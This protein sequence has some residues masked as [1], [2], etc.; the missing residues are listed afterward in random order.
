M[1]DRFELLIGNKISDIKCKNILV[2]G[3]GGVGSY[4]VESLVR[5]GIE[6]ITLID[7]DIIDVTNLN[8]QLM[9]DTTNIGKYKTDVL[10]S[11]IKLIN[12]NIKVITKTIFLN[13]DN[14]SIVTKD[15]DYVVDACDTVK[16]KISLI[17]TC[18]N[19]GIKLISV[20]GT[21]NKMDPS[22]I[23]ITDIYKTEYDPLAKI[24]R[25]E[26]RKLKIKK[27]KVVCSLEKPIKNNIEKIPS[28]SFVPAIAGLYVTSYIINDIVGDLHV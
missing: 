4:V 27:L 12:P 25:R 23:K 15:Y 7:N 28:N 20:M 18:N 14:I 2:V 8:R 13:E 21:G 10:E 19:L 6:N 3:L 11:R 9:T 17:K 1:F 16:T 22:K 24:I 26:C 5:S